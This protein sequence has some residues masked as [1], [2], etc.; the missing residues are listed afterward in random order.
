[1]EK[2]RF[3]TYTWYIDDSE[4]NITSIRIYGL[5]ENNKNICVRVDNFTPFVYIELPNNIAWNQAK[6]QLVGSK[7]D[8]E[9]GD[10]KPIIKSFCL[11][12][13]LY[14]AYLNEQGER[15]SY[16]YLF[17][18][19][20]T[21]KDI[22]ILQFKLK[23]TLRIV[24]I[25]PIKLK[26]HESDADPILQ[27]TC[28]RQLYTTGW[29]DFSGKLQK[30]D[31]KITL[32]D[33]EYKVGWKKLFPYNETDKVP[34]PKIMTFD[35]EVNSTNPSVMPNVKKPGDK[36][37][38]ISCIITNNGKYDKYLL[39]LGQPDQSTTGDDVLIYYYDTESSMLEGFTKLIRTENPNIIGGYNILGFDIP[40]MIER[41]KLNMCF[42]NFDQ[43]SFHKYT[44]SKEKTIKWSSSA[45]KNQEFQFLDAEGRVFV[46]LLPLVRRDFKFNN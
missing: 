25:G 4:E 15:Q 30:D 46:D 10:K 28:C 32:C 36:I 20:S 44:H 35:I 39:S 2:G 24:G 6:A 42:F 14:G 1:M 34:I 13:K 27:L 33:Y 22:K 21:V 16:P 17:C 5:D 8:E 41:S 12:K 23:R 37:F 18:S 3:F 29:V 11:K 38:Q 26:V 43:Q 45:Y 19:F 7:L 31:E 40:Y 9:L